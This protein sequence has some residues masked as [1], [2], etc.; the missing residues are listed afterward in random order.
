MIVCCR[1]RSD[2]VDRLA[3]HAPAIGGVVRVGGDRD[4]DDVRC[5]MMVFPD[6]AAL[7]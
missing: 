2:L 4:V 5:I 3:R 7:L 6:G 1:G